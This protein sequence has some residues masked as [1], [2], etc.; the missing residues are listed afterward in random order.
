M[1][2][3]C[4][5]FRTDD[6]RKEWIW[7]EIQQGRLRQ[8]WSHP[9]A[10]LLEDGH[11]RQKDEWVPEYIRGARES[12]GDMGTT[13]EAAK[14]YGILTRMLDIGS[15]DWLVVPKMPSERSIAILEAIGS[16]TFEA[17]SEYSHIIPARHRV[18]VAHDSRADVIEIQ[19]MLRGYQTAVNRVWNERFKGLVEGL[20]RQPPTVDQADLAGVIGRLSEPFLA[21]LLDSLRRFKSHQLEDLLVQTFKKQGYTIHATR[22]YDRQGGDADLIV[23]RPLP[24]LSAID[25][26]DQKI[27][28]QVKQK[29][30]VDP[31]DKDGVEQLVRISAGDRGPRLVL[32]STADD[33]TPE[34]R[35]V[36]DE[37]GVS[38]LAGLE[39]ARAVLRFL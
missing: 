24:V 3:S 39:L 28:I 23:S 16:Y 34:C 36:A 15:G 17:E 21:E 11:L 33:F 26:F 31:D 1:M 8:G 38:L 27:Y 7:S 14:R 20:V 25:D 12:W 22:A 13:E 6:T 18:T 2:Q 19:K 5:V 4:F 35:R 32:V 30:G 37:H 10:S 9:R 29:T